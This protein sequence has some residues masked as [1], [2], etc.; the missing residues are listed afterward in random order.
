M[1]P[2]STPPHTCAI[3]FKEWAGVCDALADG[4]QS[5]ILRKGGIAEDAGE[6]RPEHPSFWLYPTHLHEAQQ[7]LRDTRAPAAKPLPSGMLEL[8]ALA[9]VECMTWVDHPDMLDA[10][11]DLHVWTSE[12]VLK[13][14][15]YRR[16]GLWVLGVRV[17]RAD[18]PPR[19]VMTQEQSGCKSWVP[20]DEPVGTHKLIPTLDDTTLNQRM[21]RIRALQE[22]DGGAF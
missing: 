9:L 13:R 17:L 21:A 3:A 6:F 14:F 19:I 22:S 2:E 7:G 8:P 4:R 15:E 1:I 20:L 11:S 12:T 16:P 10:I 5:L 18:P